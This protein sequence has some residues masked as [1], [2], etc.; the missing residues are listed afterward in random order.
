[1][2]AARLGRDPISEDPRIDLNAFLEP[3]LGA[4]V[5]GLVVAGLLLLL[6]AILEARRIARL[7]ER[8]EGLTR[9]AS[10]RSFEA[11]LEAHLEKVF[12]VARELDE[13]SARSAILEGNSRR[14]IQ[15]IGLVRFNP[16]EETGGNQSFAFALLDARGDGFVVSSLHS[17]SGTRVYAKSLAAGQADAPLSTEEAQAVEQALAG[18]ARSGPRNEGERSERARPAP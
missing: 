3:Y 1:V 9:G 6:L 14:A 5:V 13:L 8:L 12:Q 10:G 11:I 17:R 4:I 18:P 15:R 7:Q 16:F 2:T